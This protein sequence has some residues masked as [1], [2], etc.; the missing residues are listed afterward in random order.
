MP[1]PSFSRATFPFVPLAPYLEAVG[2]QLYP[3][4][5]PSNR[6]TRLWRWSLDS[7]WELLVSL[8]FRF[9]PALEF[10]ASR[11]FCYVYFLPILFTPFVNTLTVGSTISLHPFACRT[12]AE[13]DAR[14]YSDILGSID[15][16]RY[17]CSVGIVRGVVSSNVLPTTNRRQVETRGREAGQ[18]PR[19]AHAVHVQTRLVSSPIVISF[20]S[21]RISSSV[22]NASRQTRKSHIQ[23][24]HDIRAQRYLLRVCYF[25]SELSFAIIDSWVYTTG[26]IEYGRGMYSTHIKFSD[27]IELMYQSKASYWFK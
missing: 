22:C 15:I 14:G 4:T 3:S 5:L 8:F 13:F 1:T 2:L 20:P 11:P 12:V 9:Q 7:R 18:G 10:P 19:H 24:F 27:F 26:N 25:L 23:R 16:Y 6:T 21:D 17:R